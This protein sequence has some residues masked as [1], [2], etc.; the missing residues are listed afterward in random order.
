MSAASRV[1]NS[2]SFTHTGQDVASMNFGWPFIF[3]LCGGS[4]R[5]D[6]MC[7]KKRSGSHFVWPWPL[8][9]SFFFLNEQH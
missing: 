6:W 3:F 9:G 1:E 4:K 7:R 2:D 5:A 8:S